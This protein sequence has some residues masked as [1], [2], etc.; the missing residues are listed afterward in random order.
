[1][2]D[3]PYWRWWMGKRCLVVGKMKE[4]KLVTRVQWVGPPSGVYGMVVLTFE[5][6]ST[7][8]VAPARAYRPRKTDVI[9][10]S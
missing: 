4:F 7:E 6:G 10:A 2:T 3:L 1:M 5:D 8:T 9:V